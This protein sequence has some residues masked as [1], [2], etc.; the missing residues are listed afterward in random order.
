[1]DFAWYLFS[2]DKEKRTVA[3]KC[4][5][6]GYEFDCIA[7]DINR[8]HIQALLHNCINAKVEDESGCLVMLTFSND[9][10]WKSFCDAF[11]NS[12]KP[13]THEENE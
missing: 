6:D 7:D 10:D 9:M 11:L 2:F 3:I 1:M 8:L 13:D 5:G 12:T 4:P